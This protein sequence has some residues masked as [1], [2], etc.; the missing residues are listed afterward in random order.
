MITIDEI[1]Y[2]LD[3]GTFTAVDLVNAHIARIHEVN[4]VF[5]AVLEVNPDALDIAKELD[6]EMKLHG[7]R[8]P[9]RDVPILLKDNIYTED[10]MTTSAGLYA[11]VGARPAREGTAVHNLRKAGAILLVNSN[12]SEFAN[13]RSTNA[14]DGW[15]P[16][17]GQT[18]GAF[19]PLQASEGSSSGSGVAVALGLAPAALGTEALSDR[20]DT[21][22]PMTRTVKDAALILSVIAG[23]S[24]Y[25][26]ATET[27]PFADIPDYAS[28][29]RRPDLAGIRLGVPRR[30]I[31]SADQVI[32]SSF[33]EALKKLSE[34]GATVI[35]NVDIPAQDE[36]NA[37]D[38]RERR[39]ALEAEFKSS[40]NRWCGELTHNPENIS[41]LDDLIQ[42]VQQHPKE[43]YPRRNIERLL[44]SQN[45][46]GTDAPITREALEKMLRCC[47]DEGLLP[48]LKQDNLDAL[49]FPN[50][51]DLPST[52]AARAGFPSSPCLWASTPKEPRSRTHPKVTK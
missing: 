27:I 25:D 7:R 1:G 38:P 33:E 35:D 12:L 48:A 31:A 49:V 36:W 14:S 3:H 17:G 41:D 51:A 42:F 43:A 6:A 45:S 39:R 50:V 22:V 4:Q 47:A 19:V 13:F 2:G 5:N 30:A 21:V 8:G 23:P 24:K 46:P 11:F 26:S 29:C 16:R 52:C 15:S 18:F 9:L 34:I 40:I 37:W 44:E 28:A 10:R 20:Q 32:M